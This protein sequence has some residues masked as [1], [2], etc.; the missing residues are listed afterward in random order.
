MPLVPQ[1]DSSVVI[2]DMGPGLFALGDVTVPVSSA[3][4]AKKSL[5]FEMDRLEKLG[6]IEKGL[7]GYSSPVLLVKHKQPKSLQ[8]SHRFPSVKQMFSQDQ[9]CFSIS[10]RLFRCNR[11]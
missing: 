11:E 8:S 2:H 9:S 4:L 6:I 1:M 7:T 5:N 10:A 3:L